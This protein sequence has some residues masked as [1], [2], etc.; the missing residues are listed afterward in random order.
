MAVL[1]FSDVPEMLPGARPGANPAQREQFERLSRRLYEEEAEE[2]ALETQASGVLSHADSSGKELEGMF[3]M[4]DLA[5]V[6]ML[7]AEA[8][9]MEHAVGTLLALAAA[10]T[11][12]SNGDH[13][14]DLPLRDVGIQDHN[15]FPSLIDA[16]GWQVP[17]AHL[18]ADEDLGNRWR[19]HVKAAADKP[20]P[21]AS[22]RPSVVQGHKKQGKQKKARLDEQVQLWT[23]YDY[24]HKAGQQRA[25]RRIQ[26]GRSRGA[27]R[28]GKGA[29]RDAGWAVESGA[30]DVEE[31]QE[32]RIDLSSV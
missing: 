11:D 20:A 7:R 22:C 10:T 24:R 8:P 19:D 23:D 4:L 1:N 28:R 17:A 5:V 12:L 6:K 21:K 29:G 18:Q 30:E 32:E 31:E 15:R 2:R 26:Y 25:Q 9:S 16:D 13:V 3:P 27:D 14:V